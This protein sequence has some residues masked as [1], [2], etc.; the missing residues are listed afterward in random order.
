MN[1]VDP[2][3]VETNPDNAS[4]F[5]IQKNAREELSG[6]ERLLWA[7]QPIAKR[8]MLY[9]FAIYFFAIPWTAFS[10]FWEAMALSPLFMETASQDQQYVQKAFGIVFPLFGLPFVLIG[11]GMLLSPFFAYGKAKKTIYAITDRRAMVINCRSGREVTSFPYEGWDEPLNR[12]EK[13]DGSGSL[14]FATKQVSGRHGRT[15]NVKTGFEHVPGVREVEV[16]LR[17]AIEGYK[18]I[19]ALAQEKTEPKV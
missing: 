14:F 18:A 10:L 7:G 4:A 11:F 19:A 12:T 6:G 13:T 15:R 5:D 1:T 8:V 9:A 3:A 16:K 17:R 2:Y